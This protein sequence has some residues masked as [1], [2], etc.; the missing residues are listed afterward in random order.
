MAGSEGKVKH[1][2]RGRRV[3]AIEMEIALTDFYN[4]KRIFSRP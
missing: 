2:P 3:A 1:S 4:L